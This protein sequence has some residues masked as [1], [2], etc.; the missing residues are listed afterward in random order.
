LR[1]SR[2]IIKTPRDPVKPALARR[3][4][5]APVAGGYNVSI[6]RRR[7]AACCRTWLLAM[8]YLDNNSTTRVDPAVVDAMAP[9][10][11][12]QFG[13][14]S[15]LHA[16]GQAARHAIET[17]RAHVAA[18]IGAKPREIIFTSGGTE[19]DNLA[20]LGALAAAPARRHVVTTAVEHVAVH[21]LCQRLAGQGLRVSFVPVDRDGR[22]DLAAFEAALDDDTALASVMHANNETGV[23]FS[24]EAV[25][26]LCAARGVPLH[27][28]AVQTAGKLPI[29]VAALG[30]GLVS[31]SGHKFHG[32][33]GAG[34]LYVGRG[35]RLRGQQ[36]GG[37]QERDIRPGTENV[38]AVVGMGEAARLARQRLEAGAMQRVAEL[39]DRLEHGILGAVEFARVIGGRSPRTC[40]TTTIGFE[41]LE[42]EAVLI[43]L[44]ERGVCAS[45]GAAC[46]SGSLEPS[47]VLKAMGIDERVAHGAVRFSL[48]HETTVVEIDQAIETIA[49]VTRQLAALG[50]G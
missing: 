17:A 24:V 15:S 31:I 36:V 10:W 19:A 42:A 38:A 27:V 18:L 45:S 39:R 8:I 4:T 35:V 28:D 16:M 13:N 5:G 21:S 26:R 48:S 49:A 41:A 25:A 33:K 14:A 20:I 34:A 1:F 7:D 46:S 43:A 22:L 12:D 47:H 2:R 44:S 23:I 9:F 32:P 40:N 6:R 29:D 3:P 30:A 50:V 11:R 37:H